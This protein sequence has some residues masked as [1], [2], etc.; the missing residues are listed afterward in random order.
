MPF[1]EQGVFSQN[2]NTAANSGCP[3]NARDVAAVALIG[4]GRAERE[5]LV[6]M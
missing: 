4:A 5:R 6:V 3:A 1:R 2:R